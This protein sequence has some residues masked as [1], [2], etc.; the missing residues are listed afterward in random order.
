M[1]KAKP[2]KNKLTKK[3]THIQKKETKARK[4]KTR[5]QPNKRTPK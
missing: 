4:R 2:N 5:E 1:A 3:H